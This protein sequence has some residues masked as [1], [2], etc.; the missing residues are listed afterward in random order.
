LFLL[1]EA[2]AKGRLGSVK[3]TRAQVGG[4]KEKAARFVRDVLDDP[5]RAA[6][7]EDE[8]IEDYAARRKIQ[9]IENP[10]RGGICMPKPTR[11]E[12]EER[13]RQLEEEN[14]ELQDQLDQIAD[15]A[16]PPEEDED[17]GGQEADEDAG[18]E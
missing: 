9:I 3:L 15:I 7:I 17:G 18:E 2:A 13:I 11:S 1:S 10:S 8:D 6:E 4:R 5:E 12:L 16:A 14:D